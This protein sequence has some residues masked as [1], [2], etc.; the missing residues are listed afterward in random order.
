MVPYLC[1]ASAGNGRETIQSR[2]T[3][4]VPAHDHEGHARRL[5]PAPAGGGAP[6]CHHRQIPPG[7][8]GLC[9]A[10]ETGTAGGEGNRPG[11]EG[12][13]GPALRRRHGQRQAGGPEHLFQLPGLGGVPGETPPPP[14]G[15]LPGP[16]AGTA[17]GGLSAPAGRGEGGGQLAALLPHG[18]PGLHGD[19]G[20]GAEVCHRPGPARGAG[21][22]GREGEGPAGPPHPQTVP[23][24]GQVLPA[25][26]MGIPTA[27]SAPKSSSPGP[28][29]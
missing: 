8:A 10:P 21:L 23:G 11:L 1:P 24:A 5:S 29:P 16:G 17:Q 12:R 7:G 14:A 15:T 4:H 2:R 13:P 27:P 9:P 26:W 20:V 25:A 22:G 18:D 19:P 28:R 3:H 6:P